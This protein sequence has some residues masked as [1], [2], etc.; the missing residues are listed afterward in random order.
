M[1]CDGKAEEMY[2]VE[3]LYIIVYCLFERKILRYKSR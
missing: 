2:A 3:V 1:S